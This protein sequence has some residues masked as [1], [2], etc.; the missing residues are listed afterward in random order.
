MSSLISIN[1]DDMQGR[2]Y[3]VFI[4]ELFAK[5]WGDDHSLR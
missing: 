2:R 5:T 4:D 3:L 1:N